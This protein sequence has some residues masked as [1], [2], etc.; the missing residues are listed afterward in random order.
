MV[1]YNMVHIERARW[2]P[3]NRWLIV[4]FLWPK[5][6]VKS[7]C[8]FLR[9]VLFNMLLSCSWLCCNKWTVIPRFKT[10]LSS[11]KRERAKPKREGT[12]FRRERHTLSCRSPTSLFP[13]CPCER[14]CHHLPVSSLRCVAPLLDRRCRPTPGGQVL[15]GP[16][17]G[18]KHHQV[19]PSLS[20]AQKS[21]QP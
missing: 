2:H 18:D 19:H 12:S 15:F 21:T 5:Q 8:Q 20:A 6:Q 16:F 10:R 7:P 4:S 1:M 9:F 11:S 13:L 17:A 14:G 3:K